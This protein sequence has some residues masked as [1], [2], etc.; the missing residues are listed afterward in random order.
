MNMSEWQPHITVA[1]VIEQDGKFL[2]VEEESDGRIVFNQP[3]GHLEEGESLL[4][5]VARET[6][7]ETARHFIPEALI[8]IYSWSNAESGI[9]YMRF[10]FRGQC[11]ERDPARQL[12]TG[13]IAI[14]WMSRDELQG[15]S[16]RLRSPLVLRAIDDY[17]TGRRYP[18]GLLHELYHEAHDE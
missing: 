6:L 17:L 1:A 15:Q 10:A 12:D 5:G 14:H 3:A 11:G 13:I 7:E 16:E 2:M 9:T 18:L 4:E 8:G